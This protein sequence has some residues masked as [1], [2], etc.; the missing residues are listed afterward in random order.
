MKQELSP[1]QEK[2]SHSYLA[3]VFRNGE[4]SKE[5]DICPRTLYRH[6]EEIKKK[7]R[8]RRHVLLA[9]YALQK[10][11]IT[12]EVVSEAINAEQSNNSKD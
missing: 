7:L 8:I 9:F 1:I 10:G 12:Q 2:S 5:L 6:L 4:I 11:I 3:K